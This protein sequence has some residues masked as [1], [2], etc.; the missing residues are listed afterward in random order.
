VQT[1]VVSSL[2][3]ALEPIAFRFPALAALAGRA[4]IGGRREVALATF[5][6]S[7]LARDCH[8]DPPLPDAARAE[9]AAGAK[10][11]MSTLNLPATV[12]PALVR[13]L[14]ATGRS[15]PIAEE[16]AAALSAVHTFLD[17]AALRELQEFAATLTRAPEGERRGA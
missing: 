7:K 6:A 12:R 9:R 13:L 1:T 2:P 14:E 16:F 4:Q 3:H 17:G 5:V 8:A 10:S 15:R 11:W